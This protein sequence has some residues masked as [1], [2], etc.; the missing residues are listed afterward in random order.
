MIPRATIFRRDELSTRGAQ[1]SAWA[2]IHEPTTRHALENRLRA[3]SWDC[4]LL[5]RL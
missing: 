3:R 4:I 2:M 5:G 1:R